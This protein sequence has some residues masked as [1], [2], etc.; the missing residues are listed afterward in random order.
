MDSKFLHLLIQF[1]GVNSGHSRQ[2]I[3]PVGNRTLT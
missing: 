2:G 1:E 3:G